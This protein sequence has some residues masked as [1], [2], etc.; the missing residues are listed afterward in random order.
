MQWWLLP[1]WSPEPRIKYSTFNARVETV[2][3]NSSFRE[4]FKRRRCLIPARGWYEWQ[5][6]T[7]GKQPWY[8]H[9]ASGEV[10]AFAGVWDHWEQAGQTIESCAIIVGESNATTQNVHP[11]MPL[12]IPAERQ[13]LWL[14][15]D[16]TDSGKAR[17][18]LLPVPDK[19][20]S[21][22][23]VGKAVGNARNDGPDLIEPLPLNILEPQ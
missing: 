1:S 23:P 8:F 21:L 20:I 5:Q 6:R 12:I 17:E 19:V 7:S 13:A 22:Y 2:S 18:L 14:S 3:T 16:L 11:R 15:T 10:L 4:P 9:A